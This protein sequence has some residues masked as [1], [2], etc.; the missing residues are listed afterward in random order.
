M[1]Q[2]R[3]D[4][5]GVD[6]MNVTTDSDFRKSLEIILSHEDAT[7]VGRDYISI[8]LN[9]KVANSEISPESEDYFLQNTDNT[10]KIKSLRQCNQGA[11]FLIFE[12]MIRIQIFESS[13]TKEIDVIN[14]QPNHRRKELWVR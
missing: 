6:T 10:Y 14:G 12:D 4:Y 3:S 1:V 13:D 5:N 9:R 7:I 11:T 8:L 2:F